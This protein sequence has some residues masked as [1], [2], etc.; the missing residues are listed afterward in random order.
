MSGKLE[1]KKCS[2]KDDELNFDSEFDHVD[3]LTTNFVD[4]RVVGEIRQVEE[5]NLKVF[6]VID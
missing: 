2:N 5:L 6:S 3:S 4:I 1:E